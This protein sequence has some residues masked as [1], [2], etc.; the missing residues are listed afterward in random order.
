MDKLLK[1]NICS[2]PDNALN[3]EVGDL[4]QR[5]EDCG[6]RG[7][8]EYACRSWYK[9]LVVTEHQTADVISALHGLLERKF[10]LWLEVL[11]ILGVMEDAVD[12]LNVIIKWLNE[13][14]P[15]RQLDHNDPWH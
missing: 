2:I 6:I 15:D 3:S 1:K 10:L 4:S 7:A 8:L 5:I 12:A 9:H 14:R 11:S 13:V